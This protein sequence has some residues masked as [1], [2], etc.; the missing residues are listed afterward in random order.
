MLSYYDRSSKFIPAHWQPGILVDLVC[1]LGIEEHKLLKGTGIFL[2]DVTKKTTL[3][4]IEQFCQI[5]KNA[6]ALLNSSDLSFNFGSRILPGN[7]D[8]FSAALNNAAHLAEALD[9]VGSYPL[10]AFPLFRA[11]IV[12]NGEET[13]IEWQ[14]VFGLA[15]LKPQLIEMACTAILS[16]TKWKS[17]LARPWRFEFDYLKPP[18]LE[19]YEVHLADMAGSSKRILFNRAACRMWIKNDYLFD[20]WPMSSSTVYHYSMNEIRNNR[21][22]QIQNGFCGIAS[23]IIEN[24]LKNGIQL[25]TL[26][27]HL[28]MSPATLKRKFKL[29]NTSFQKLLD[30]LRR[31]KSVDL[32]LDARLNQEKIAG[33]LGIRDTANFRRSF[34]RWTGN[35]PSEYLLSLKHINV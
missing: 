24:E 7:F 27:T 10:T 23:K 12:S 1:K 30:D 25:N 13:G 32:M 35:S 19:Q 20:S 3:I 15:D 17:G 18:Y 33:I 14:D 26:A 31:K 34:K 29:H 16:F 9:I 21:R 2:S 28:E 11:N 5:I 4:S 8:H 6:K 22:Y